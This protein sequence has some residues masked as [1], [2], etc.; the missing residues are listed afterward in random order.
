MTRERVGRCW[1]LDLAMCFRE[2]IDT[3]KKRREDSY[4]GP[5]YLVSYSS[6]S[7]T[8]YIY[9]PIPESGAFFPLTA[10]ILSTV[11]LHLQPICSDTPFRLRVVFIELISSAS[12]FTIDSAIHYT[13]NATSVDEIGCYLFW[14]TFLHLSVHL[15]RSLFLMPLQFATPK[16]CTDTPRSA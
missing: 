6:L 14:L 15:S 2:L 1:D 10:Y 9:P 8:A 12:G 3:A 4:L 7:L 13:K 11:S 5:G 16:D